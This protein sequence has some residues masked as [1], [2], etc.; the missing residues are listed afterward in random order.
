MATPCWIRSILAVCAPAERVELQSLI[1]SI[2]HPLYTLGNPFRVCCPFSG[3]PLADMRILSCDCPPTAHTPGLPGLCP[4]TSIISRSMALIALVVTAPPD[5]VTRRYFEVEIRSISKGS[6]PTGNR[7][8]PANSPSK[9]SSL[10]CRL[11]SLH[12]KMPAIGRDRHEH[13]VVGPCR[14]HPHHLQIR[15]L[16]LRFLGCGARA[17]RRRVYGDAALRAPAC[18][19]PSIGDRHHGRGNPS[20]WRRGCRRWTRTGRTRL[21]YRHMLASRDGIVASWWVIA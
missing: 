11:A 20:S 18:A 16:H 17:T 4:S 13:P 1:A 21:R 9:A 6:W 10:Y 19:G 15:D 12:P 8:N 5:K 14:S 2:H 7:L 3:H